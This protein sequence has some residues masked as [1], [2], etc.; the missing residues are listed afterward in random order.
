MI[1]DP[2][3]SNTDFEISAINEMANQCSSDWVQKLTILKSAST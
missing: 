1:Y 2:S 3:K